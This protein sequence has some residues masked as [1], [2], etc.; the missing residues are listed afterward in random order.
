MMSYCLLGT[1]FQFWMIKI[2]QIWVVVRV[3]QQSECTY[4]TELCLNLVTYGLC[5]QSH[6]SLGGPM[7]CSPSGSSA[8]PGSSFHG[9]FQAK[10]LEWVAISYPS[11]SSQQGSNLCFLYLLHWQADPLLPAPPGIYGL[12]QCKMSVF[13]QNKIVS[14]NCDWNYN[15]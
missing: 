4:C 11:V 9:I 5:A 1:K 8:P 15:R 12:P 13:I 6:P 14:M 10:I 7:N 2:F 3:A